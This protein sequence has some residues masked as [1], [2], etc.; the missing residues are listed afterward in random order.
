MFE[1]RIGYLES[2]TSQMLLHL[3]EKT[4]EKQKKKKNTNNLYHF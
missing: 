2:D 3:L 1:L 4:Y